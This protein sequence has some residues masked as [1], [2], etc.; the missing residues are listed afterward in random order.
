MHA[1]GVT[2]GGGG[3]GGY[4]RKDPLEVSSKEEFIGPFVA[5]SERV[6]GRTGGRTALSIQW[7]RSPKWI[8]ECESLLFFPPAPSKPL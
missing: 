4:G 8:S 2:S 3:G 6:G 5:H 7:D 1:G